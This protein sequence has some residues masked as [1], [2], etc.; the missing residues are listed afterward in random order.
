MSSA[1]APSCTTRYAARYDCGQCRL[2]SSAS[3][4][5]DPR[6]AWRTRL[7]SLSVPIAVR[8]CRAGAVPIADS[9]I[10]GHGSAQSKDR[11]EM[12]TRDVP[13]EV[14][15]RL[16]PVEFE[17]ASADGQTFVY[18]DSGEGPLVVLLH[19]FPDLPQGWAD[20]AA[21]LNGAGYR[22]VVPY[23][24]GYHPDT[25]VAGRDYSGERIA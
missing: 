6:R 16:A 19:G 24:R 21:V 10:F 14:P 22:T 20:A 8:N 3:A 13:K 25:I 18:S 4:G 9:F 11:I 5:S 1:A 7:R 23:L 15:V 12:D 2:N 17:R